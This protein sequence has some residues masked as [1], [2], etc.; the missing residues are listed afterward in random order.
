VSSLF[1]EPVRAHVDDWGPKEPCLWI[2]LIADDKCL[3]VRGD[4]TLEIWPIEHVTADWRWT[5]TRWEDLQEAIE[6]PPAVDP[7]GG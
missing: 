3:I 7:E 4:G 5:G 6:A 2:G 1:N